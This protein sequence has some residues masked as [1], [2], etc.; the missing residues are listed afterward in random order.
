MDDSSIVA[1]KDTPLS[2]TTY[3]EVRVTTNKVNIPDKYRGDK[4]KLKAFLI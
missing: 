4:R 1:K 2:K 3:Y